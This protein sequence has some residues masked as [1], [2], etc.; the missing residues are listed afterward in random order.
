[1]FIH[2]KINNIFAFY[3]RQFI[4]NGNKWIALTCFKPRMVL[5]EPLFNIKAKLPNQQQ[6][7]LYLFSERR[8]KKL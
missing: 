4:W 3:S 8:V 5:E 7:E 6:H 2:W 1:M